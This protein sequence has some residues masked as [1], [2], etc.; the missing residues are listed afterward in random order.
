MIRLIRAA[1]KERESDFVFVEFNAWL[2][3]G[4]DDARAALLEI[5]AS[6]LAQ[7]AEQRKSGLDKARNCFNASTGSASPN[8]Q[9]VRLQRS[10][11]G[12]LQQ[13]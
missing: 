10:R 9:Q 12:Y 13:A 7:E 2:Y 4:Y 11:S 5:I 6:T 1:L 3:Q 8:S